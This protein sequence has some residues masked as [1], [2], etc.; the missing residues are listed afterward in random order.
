MSLQVVKIHHGSL[1]S[2]SQGRVRRLTLEPVLSWL[3]YAKL[4]HASATQKGCTQSSE[5]MKRREPHSG[6]KGRILSQA[7]TL[8]RKYEMKRRVAVADRYHP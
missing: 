8:C 5:M 3:K 2:A 1:T 7:T 6:K 4:D